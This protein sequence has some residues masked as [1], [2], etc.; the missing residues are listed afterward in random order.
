[1][2][3]AINL[4]SHITTL[5]RVLLLTDYYMISQLLKYTVS[6]HHLLLRLH[7]PQIR[8]LFLL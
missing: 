7:G 3:L 8:I 4:P 5:G 1:M 6:H 2:Y